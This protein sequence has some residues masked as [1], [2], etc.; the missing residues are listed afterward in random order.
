MPLVCPWSS[1]GQPRAPRWGRSQGRHAPWRRAGPRQAR[2]PLAGK[3]GGLCGWP[4]LFTLGSR[5]GGISSS[6]RQPLPPYTHYWTAPPWTA[7]RQRGGCTGAPGRVLVGL[8]G[9]LCTRISERVRDACAVRVC[10]ARVR[11]AGARRCTPLPPPASTSGH[12]PPLPRA[13][14]SSPGACNPK[15]TCLTPSFPGPCMPPALH[16]LFSGA[17]LVMHHPL[18]LGSQL[19]TPPPRGCSDCL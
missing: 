10:G 1:P 6:S 13:C 17:F 2:P 12:V 15:T 19:G 4:A 14:P 8:W 3:G 9:A 16:P 5:R 18:G 7:P 11:R